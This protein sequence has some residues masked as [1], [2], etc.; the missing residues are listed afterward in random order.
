MCQQLHTNRLEINLK[1]K[2]SKQTMLE[3][4]PIWGHKENEIKGGLQE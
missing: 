2:K 3:D 1:K 4:K